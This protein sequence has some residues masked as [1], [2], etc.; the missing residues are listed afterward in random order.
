MAVTSYIAKPRIGLF[1]S[2]ST[3]YS[4]ATGVLLEA[5]FLHLRNHSHA[6][7]GYFEDH[8]VTHPNSKGSAHRDRER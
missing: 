1:R 3:A 5:T 2:A 7:G 6:I 8:F 4:I